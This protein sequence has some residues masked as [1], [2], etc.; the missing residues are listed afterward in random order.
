MKREDL[1]GK[2]YEE[3][4]TMLKNETVQFSEE[5]Q[6]KLGPEP[7]NEEAMT[8]LEEFEK[9]VMEELNEY[10]KYLDNVEYELPGSCDLEGEHFTR[11]EVAK[12]IV[13]HINKS[14][15]EW[16]Y[17]LGMYQ[18]IQLWN[19]KGL[20]TI[21]YKPYDSTLRMLGQVKYKG[22]TEWRDILV[23]NEFA[24]HC[25]EA[26]AIDT[27]WLYFLSNKHNIILDLMNAYNPQQ[28][29]DVENTPV[30]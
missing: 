7:T 11:G 17:A 22:F 20:K 15:V 26:Y 19:S 9:I 18:M 3:V 29:E 2:S 27:A 12:M 4:Q 21:K 24:A 10:D 16:K 5:I 28:M 25:R 30:A 13:K 8:I 23:I 6:S 1:N 14:E